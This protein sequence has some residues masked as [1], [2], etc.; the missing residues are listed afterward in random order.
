[1]SATTYYVS[2]SGNDSNPGTSDSLSWKTLS[3]VNKFFLRRGDQ[4]LFKRGDSWQGTL[5]PGT[6]G[7]SGIPIVYGAYGTGAK[8]IITG[9][10]AVTAW[11]NKG[12]NI[13]E[14]TT[15]VSTL[16]TCNMV[17]INGINTPMGR[18]PNTGYYYFQSHTGNT[19][20]TS[21]NLT[22]TPDWTGAEL[23]FNPNNWE[24][25]RVPITAQ[26]NGKL[27]FT[28]PESFTIR[29]DGLKFIIQND[30]R[31][32]DQQNE[33]YYN[34]STKKLSIYSTSEPV[35]VKVSTVAD[36]VKVSGK[37]YVTFKNIEFTGSNE[38]T[39]NIASANIIK[40]DS[41]NIYYSGA[42]G[43]YGGYT[44]S[45]KLTVSNCSFN[46]S[47]DGAIGV[48]SMFRSATLSANT[49]TNTGIIYGSGRPATS[50]TNN[51]GFGVAISAQGS[52]SLIENNTLTNTGYVG[53]NFNGSDIIIRNN[54]IKKFNQIN[55]DGG[56]IY[57]W[58]GMDKIN[59]P[60]N[61][62]TEIYNNIII[63]DTIVKEPGHPLSGDMGIYLDDNSNGIKVHDNTVEIPL[64][65]GIYLNGNHNVQIYNNIIFNSLYGIAF[66]HDHTSN[67]SFNYNTVIAKSLTQYIYWLDP[68][69]GIINRITANNNILDRPINSDKIMDLLIRKPSWSRPSY[70]L[71][72]WQSFSRQD[73]NSKTSPV[74]IT[75]ENNIQ[76]FYNNTKQ[77]RTF[78]LGGSTFKD[79]EGKTV[80]VSFTLQPFTSKILIGKNFENIN[81]KP[82]I[83]DQSFHI[84][85][86]KF[87]NDSVGQV[88]AYDADKNQILEFS[89]IQG[90]E[91]GFFSVDS[92]T[93]IIHTSN[94]IN[95]SYDIKINLLVRVSDNSLNS[96]SDSAT[97]SV[98]IKGT[99]I[100]PPII[101]SF[102]IPSGSFSL[103]IPIDTFKAFDDLAV[104]G[105]L[106]TENPELP[107]QNDPSWNASI[108]LFYSFS[109]EGLQILYAW[110]KDAAGNVSAS[111]SDQVVIT[112]PDVTI[113]VITAFNIPSTSTSIV[114]AISSLTAY[115]NKAVT[116][117]ILTESATAPLASDAGWTAV[118]PVSYSFAS[119]G[120]KTIYAWAKDTAGNVSESV[121]DQVVIKLPDVIKPAVTA[122]N[123]PSTSTSLVVA[124]SSLTAYDN[125]EVT[126]FM[127]T[128]SATAPLASDAGWMAGAPV[129]YSFASE[130][131]KTLYAWVKDAA[132]NISSSS[133]NTVVITLPDLSP[134][135]SEYL[136]EEI[137][138]TAIID[139]QGKNNGDIVNK[140]FRNDG[141]IGKG[142][143]FTESG[144]INL[145]QCFGENVQNEVSLSTWIQPSAT[146]LGWQGIIMHGGPNTDSYGLYLNSTTQSISFK[147][148]GT[149]N[150][151][152]TLDEVNSLWDGNWHHLAVTYNGLKK[153]IYLDGKI[154]LT[155]EAS[156]II[157]SGF[158]YNLL[159]GAGNDEINPS[160]LFK[161]DMDEVRIYNYALN[162]NEIEELYHSV[163]RILKK[164][165]ISENVTICEGANYMGWT[166]QGE[167]KR[168]LQRLESS[169]SG[170][171]SIVTTNL[172]INRGYF[173][174]EEITIK[175]GENYLSWIETGTYQQNLTSVNGC[176][177]IIVTHL[178]ILQPDTQNIELEKGWNIFSSYLVPTQLNF[179][180]L[181][182]NLQIQ[183][184]IIEVQDENG[185]TFKHEGSG[186]VN[187]I[188]EMKES[189]GYK[190]RVQ[191]SC[192]L[193]INGQ[194]V[195]LPVNIQLNEG[196]NIISFPHKESVDAMKVVYPLIEA[197]ILDKV[198]DERGNSIEYWDNS[199]EW[200]DG[201]YSFNPG[202]G[203]LIKANDHGV[204]PISGEYEKS[205]QIL[206][207]ALT[208]EHFKLIYEGNGFS[209]MNINISGLNKLNLLAGDEIAAYDGSKC[210]GT[211]KLRET[212]IYKNAVSL[213]ASASDEDVSNGFTEGNKIELRIWQINSNSEY[214]PISEIIKGDM[215]YQ[216]RGSVFAQLTEKYNFETDTV[217][218]LEFSIH[219][220]PA[221][222]F[223]TLK[224]STLPEP[225]TTIAVTDV[226]GI[227]LIDKEVQSLNE[228]LNIEHLPSGI[229]LAKTQINNE[230]RIQKLIK[231]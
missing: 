202:E 30:I 29:S 188:G 61:S 67:V 163:N 199:T 125:K 21:N 43:I 66:N 91:S 211:V 226:A 221:I 161:G 33:W 141:V 84:K 123:I 54:Y 86:P 22:G 158:G 63:G 205:V 8:P 68:A 198:Q 65:Y 4:V 95:T 92:I 15:A 16:S 162:K 159:I 126:G 46:H 182:K 190:I 114:V 97:I 137:A 101:S 51:S 115:D 152:V 142:L 170:A 217:N 81:Q 189:E 103:S 70:S 102:S 227:K 6:S 78:N 52:G 139:S 39:F 176:D 72:Q 208:L 2:N 9:F 69:E 107:V 93:G 197:G 57:T 213:K 117:F 60:S 40:I 36:L 146:R 210:V 160:L 171:D 35:N 108:P 50:G 7:A 165:N 99:D 178:N 13:W 167:Y 131:T 218:A 104:V 42:V 14:S 26:S 37:N 166:E 173:Y 150:S 206:S 180:D 76:L 106:L 201:V 156:G 85:S 157:D 23:A 200:L 153:I 124:I 231:Q 220:N 64:G 225:G 184:Q 94:E 118:A 109:Q 96:L 148:S 196:W 134:V 77:A 191:S 82:A 119:E 53:I 105:Y 136:F 129:S 186:W 17:V 11:T 10:T 49:I 111:V 120:T 151:L 229:Y 38:K 204:L 174:T 193:E 132:E 214:Q 20:I 149:T 98:N 169:A 73:I 45:D 44:N 155:I 203:Y 116:G 62:G 41:C 59:Y 110:A 175:Q 224:F 74:S 48:T 113:P 75:S 143:S 24:T 121:S 209:H 71:S 147:T 192:V 87:S 181:L 58:N 223:V 172:Y 5:I 31:T 135:F 27:T 128:E 55:H 164:I 219:P 140:V 25:K 56:G 83:S 133:S 100:S 215:I 168:V 32:L 18:E 207:N 183:N 187:N 127:L 230:F 122:F 112:L 228:T 19:S 177:S 195:L 12:G 144:Y 90:N 194:T 130:G 138:G 185:N 145:G 222:D 154:I 216:K 88:F 34:P 79:I 80:S 212:D 179:K 1:L 28:Q 3:K 47:N 89:I